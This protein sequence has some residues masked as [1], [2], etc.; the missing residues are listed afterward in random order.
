MDSVS[1]R[2]EAGEIFAFLGPN[3][4]GKTTATKMLT[5][6]LFPTSGKI[7]IDG[8]DPMHHQNE[9]R[10]RFGIVF[11][12]P[13][14]DSNMSGGENMESHGALYRVPRK[15][16]RERSELLLRAFGLWER[17]DDEVEKLSG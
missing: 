13:S 3:G 14:L 17:K 8:L 11:Q 5:T 2:V 15:L 7:Q 4:A 16:R 12:D 6:L 1:F 10:R 9:V